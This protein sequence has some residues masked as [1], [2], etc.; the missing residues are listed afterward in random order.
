[1][2]KVLVV[3]DDAQMRTVLCLYLKRMGHQVTEAATIAAAR[4]LQA[5][6]SRT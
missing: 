5:S 6:E 1:M 4:A 2:G 3:D